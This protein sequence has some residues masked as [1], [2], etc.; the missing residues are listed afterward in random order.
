MRMRS[1]LTACALAAGILLGGA[2]SALAN[3]GVDLSKFS[4]GHAAWAFN[5]E[6]A[7]AIPAKVGPVWTSA[8]AGEGE[9]EWAK[10]A[11]LGA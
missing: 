5:C 10:F 3:D 1:S 8:C 11:H 6:S 2:G 7:A 9:K 4:G